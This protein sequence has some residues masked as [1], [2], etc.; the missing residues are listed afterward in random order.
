MEDGA[1]VVRFLGKHGIVQRAR[2]GPVPSVP[3]LPSRAIDVLQRI[4]RLQERRNRKVGTLAWLGIGVGISRWRCYVPCC[5]DQLGAG[6][7]DGVV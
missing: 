7:I 3:A 4:M 2:L 1:K 5:P 6:G